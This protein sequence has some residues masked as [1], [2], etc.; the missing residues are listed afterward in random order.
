MTLLQRSKEY[1][2][3]AELAANIIYAEVQH[4]TQEMSIHGPSEDE[5][6]TLTR[7][8]SY[9]V[10]KDLRW[11]DVDELIDQV[12]HL[13]KIAAG[14]DDEVRLNESRTVDNRAYLMGR[15]FPYLLANIEAMTGQIRPRYEMAA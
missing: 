8:L 13:N 7:R 3:T 2:F 1:L 10:D 6:Q 14:A 5:V 12:V 11:A 9:L 4:F 15:Y